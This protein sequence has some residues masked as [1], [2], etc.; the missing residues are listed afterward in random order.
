LRV[1]PLRYVVGHGEQRPAAENAG[2]TAV[3]TTA[4]TGSASSLVRYDLLGELAG[5]TQLTRR[6][7]AAIVRQVGPDTFAQYRRN[8]GQFIT[9]SARLIND[10]LTILIEE[11]GVASPASRAA[12]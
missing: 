10:S 2:F 4:H 1:D 3:G 6:T 12:P 7:I 8:P 5:R 9:A 11:R